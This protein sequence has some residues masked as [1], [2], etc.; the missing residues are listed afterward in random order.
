LL[1]RG[2]KG[3]TGGINAGGGGGNGGGAIGGIFAVMP[4]GTTAGTAAGTT[5]GTAAGVTTGA[6]ISLSATFL[7][8]YVVLPTSTSLHPPKARLI[9]VNKIYMQTCLFI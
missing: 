1:I 8:I 4:A 7:E 9:T 2:I 5:A 3:I 6:G